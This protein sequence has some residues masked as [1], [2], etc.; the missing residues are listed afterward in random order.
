MTFKEVSH[1]SFT[2]SSRTRA[3]HIAPSSVNVRSTTTSTLCKRNS[4]R[5]D[6]SRAMVCWFTLTTRWRTKTPPSRW[7]GAGWNGGGHW[8][9]PYAPDTSA[10]CA[11]GRSPEGHTGLVVDDV[12][13]GTRQDRLALG[14]APE[15]VHA[16]RER[17]RPCS[18]VPYVS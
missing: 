6:T 10:A 2:G 7:R 9:T 4:S 16:Y 17:G 12:G 14:E 3:S 8:A 15:N 1:R 13:G 18:A 11:A 5:Y